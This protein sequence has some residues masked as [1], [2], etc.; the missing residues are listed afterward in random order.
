MVVLVFILLRRAP[1]ELSLRL[2]D[3][4][5]GFAGTLLSI[6]IVAPSGT[7]LVSEMVVWSF[8]LLGLG[9]H[10]SAK[11]AL[12][13][14]FGVVAANRGVKVSGPYRLVRHPM[15]LGYILSLVGILLAGPNVTNVV[16]VLAIWAFM[17]ARIVAE[18]RILM[19]DPAYQELCAV[20]RWRL[21]PGIY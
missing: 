13:R 12:R 9:V 21:V 11:F 17:V 7:P 5:V 14:S 19:R 2:D 6:L 18:E 15:Y 10:L 16:L 20:T 1:K 3:W 4:V 8:L